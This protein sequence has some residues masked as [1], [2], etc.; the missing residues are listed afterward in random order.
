MSS[1]HV[2]V[3][4]DDRTLAGLEGEWSRLL[5]ATPLASGFQS[6][7][8]AAA[9]RAALPAAD[10]GL[11]ALVVRDGLDIVGI[12]P[13]ELAPGGRLRFIGQGVSNYLGPVYRPDRVDGI[14]DALGGFLDGERRVMLVDFPGLREGSPILD[15][16][17]G[18]RV[19]GWSDVRV[20]QTATCPYVDL[21]HG[22]EAVSSR[23]KSKQRSNDTRKRK[24]L[25]RL[26]QPDFVEVTRPEEVRSALPAMFRL[27]EGRWAGRHES[28]GFAGRCRSFHEHAAQA[29]AVAG[30]V[31]LSLLR[32]DGEIV[33][34]SYG[35]RA[36]GVTSSYVIAHENRLS[37]CSPG[38]LLLLRL[39]EA[40]AKRGDPEYDFSLGEEGYKE[41][42]AT[43][44][45]GVFRALS[46]RD[47]STAGVKARLEALGGRAWVAARSVG[48]LRAV[49]REGLRRVAFGRS[50]PPEAADVP[51]LP[52]GDGGT[53]AVHRVARRTGGA[54]V[55]VR[56][57]TYRQMME[58]LSPRLFQL[59]VNRCFRGDSLLALSAGDRLLGVVWRADP[60]R[61]A[62]VTGKHDVR[63]DDPVYYHPVA[64][65][66]HAVCDVVHGLACL[67]AG[68]PGLIV[69]A[70]ERL[71]GDDVE[72]VGTFADDHR[73]TAGQPDGT[74][75]SAR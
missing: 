2:D 57:W 72:H 47:H 74:V 3:V 16:L 75:V 38:A 56:V 54:E 36:G 70:Q 32:V 15:A 50:A 14:L 23:R 41:A 30:H 65:P 11:F 25:Q 21:S 44:K 24:A 28:G 52:A 31:M 66:G 53:W 48:W 37:F 19:P 62:L 58:H 33:A 64:A 22:W 59:A 40:A 51:G 42:W 8:W 71:A 67:E 34:F 35:V 60:T 9:C 73:F 6:L 27:F 55:A 7:A 13:T 61:R 1:F 20:M 63:V 68:A 29:L 5:G 10:T 43:G 46:W 12:L 45:R 17:R 4:T 18:R 69:V 26:G 39:L 49:R